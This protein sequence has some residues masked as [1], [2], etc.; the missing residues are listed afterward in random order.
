MNCEFCGD[1][2]DMDDPDVQRQVTS[3]VHG[4]KL[5]SPVLRE[6]TGK[7]AHNECV[8]MVVNGV[9]PGTEPLFDV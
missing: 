1:P 8:Q 5:D 4:P 7:V 2:V 9:A 6:Q 3:W